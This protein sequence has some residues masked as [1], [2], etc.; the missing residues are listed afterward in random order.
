MDYYL[1][2]NP[3]ENTSEGFFS[4][5]TICIFSSSPTTLAETYQYAFPKK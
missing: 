4:G 3:A 1:S 2:A 5:K